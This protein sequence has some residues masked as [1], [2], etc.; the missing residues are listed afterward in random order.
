M[1]GATMDGVL[2]G[3]NACDA[4]HAETEVLPCCGSR[5]WARA[6]A[7]RRPLAEPAEVLRAAIEV[8]EE[9]PEGAWME[10]FASHPRI[11]QRAAPPSATSRSAAWSRGEQRSAMLGDTHVQQEL[12]TWNELYEGRFGRVFLICAAGLSARE[13]LAELKRRM[14]NEPEAELV[15]AAEQQQRITALRLQH[16]ME[17]R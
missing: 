17:T 11:G 9:L 1:I 16:W 5:A 3:W 15:E 14:N 7:A 13:I 10:A 8:W 2:E 12:Q 4:E 6:I